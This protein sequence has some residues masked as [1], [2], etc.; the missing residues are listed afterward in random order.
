MSAPSTPYEPVVAEEGAYPAPA[1]T[2]SASSANLRAREGSL[3]LRRQAGTA[4]C[5]IR[6]VC[7]SA[8]FSIALP[9]FEISC[10]APEVV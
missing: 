3:A 7:L 5:G 6:G 10:P 1:A 4:A 9:V 2:A 8:L